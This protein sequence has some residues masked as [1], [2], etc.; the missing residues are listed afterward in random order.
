MVAWDRKE[1]NV[2][3]KIFSDG[4][5]DE[6]LELKKK[7]AEEVVHKIQRKDSGL[8]STLL[9]W[10]M[11]D[12]LVNEKTITDFFHDEIFLSSFW[13]SIWLITEDLKRYREMFNEAKTEEDLE[14]LKIKLFEDIEKGPQSWSSTRA[15]SGSSTVVG[16]WSTKS[17]WVDTQRSTVGSSSWSE[18]S[19]QKSKVDTRKGYEIDN[20][21]VEVPSEIKKRWEN[22]K[23]KEKPELEPFACAMKAYEVEKSLWH[24]KN[25]KYLTVVDF[26]KNQLTQNRF[27]VVNL[28]IDTVEYSEMCG[29]GEGSG[30]QERATSFSN[31]RG[32]HQS[33]LWA[34]ITNDH[35][36]LNGKRTWHWNFPKWQEKSNKASRWIAIHPVGSLVYKTWKSTSDWCFTIPR[37]QKYVDEILLKIEWWSLVFA[38]AKS[39]DYFAQSN[40]FHKNSDGSYAA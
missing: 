37:S 2:L 29:H 31:K 21:D 27:F 22:L 28:D 13:E 6:L 36:R 4:I 14:E 24:L 8:M 9:E 5:S 7:L 40:Y 32:S 20:F 33:S 12:Y 39:E 25:M 35:S 17:S 10:S 16:A 15:S 26:T 38:Y 34:Y 1:W 11:V 19:N 3:D 23:W 18:L 30:G